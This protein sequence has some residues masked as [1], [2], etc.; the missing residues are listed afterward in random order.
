MLE[1]QG[2]TGWNIFCKKHV[3]TRVPVSGYAK[4]KENGVSSRLTRPPVLADTARVSPTEAM[5]GKTKS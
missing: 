4:K 2:K 5:G 1:E 3:L